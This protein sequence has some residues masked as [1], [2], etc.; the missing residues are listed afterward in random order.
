MKVFL[1]GLICTLSVSAMSNAAVATFGEFKSEA[2]RFAVLLKNARS[3]TYKI[4][5]DPSGIL[6]VYI[7][8]P[9]ENKLAAFGADNVN[10]I[11]VQKNNFPNGGYSHTY[12]TSNGFGGPSEIVFLR[13]SE[14]DAAFITNPLLT[15]KCSV[16]R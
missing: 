1:A 7:G 8:Q 3:C 9:A 2:L 15:A 13:T 5:Y 16:G 11:L 6:S 10:G 4:N 12:V 14:G